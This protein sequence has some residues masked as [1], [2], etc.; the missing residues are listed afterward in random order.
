M[1]IDDTDTEDQTIAV[2]H[3]GDLHIHIHRMAGIDQAISRCEHAVLFDLFQ[4][5][6]FCKDFKERFTV[7]FIDTGHR[8][9]FCRFKEVACLRYHR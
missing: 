1:G 4:D 2:M 8:I 6:F 9:A 3:L 5:V 7:I